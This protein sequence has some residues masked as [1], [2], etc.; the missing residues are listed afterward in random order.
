[1]FQN[2]KDK[3]RIKELENDL[4]EIDN[5]RRDLKTSNDNLS[6][7]NA[8]LTRQRDELRSKVREQTQ[9][10]AYFSCIKIMKEIEKNE[11]NKEK[12]AKEIRER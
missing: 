3:E 7:T 8:G 10:D 4:V 5:K 12:L 9:A 1:M 11:P 2:R 6:I